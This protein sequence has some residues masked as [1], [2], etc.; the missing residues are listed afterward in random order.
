MMDLFHPYIHIFLMF[1]VIYLF[2]LL[3]VMSLV[4][5]SSI[6]SHTVKDMNFASSMKCEFYVYSNSKQR[7]SERAK[8]HT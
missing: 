8:N 5:R 3:Y 6:T 1:V 4:F 7:S 2:A